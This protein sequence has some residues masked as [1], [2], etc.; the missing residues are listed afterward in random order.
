MSGLEVVPDVSVLSD[1][2]IPWEEAVV[3]RPVVLEEKP[4]LPVLSDAPIPSEEA[5]VAEPVVSEERPVV[6]LPVTSSWVVVPAPV[7]VEVLKLSPPVAVEVLKL[8][9][10]VVVEEVF[11]LSVP[12]APEEDVR[13]V[14][15]VVSLVPLVVALWAAAPWAGIESEVPSS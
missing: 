9:P 11:R 12:V 2:P 7:A 10:A 1:A 3:S 4:V 5:V 15:P 13:P 6:P 14:L 8:S